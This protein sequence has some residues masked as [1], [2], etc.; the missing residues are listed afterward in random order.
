MD[1][2]E[3]LYRHSGSPEDQ[4]AKLSYFWQIPTAHITYSC[5][6]EYQMFAATQEGATSK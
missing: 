1:C 2:D 4:N 3:I 6:R 5:V